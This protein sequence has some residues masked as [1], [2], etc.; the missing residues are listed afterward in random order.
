MLNADSE[1][2][3]MVTSDMGPNARMRLFSS[4]TSPFCRKVLVCALARAISV[5]EVFVD[6]RASDYRANNPLGQIPTMAF[7]NGTCLYDSDVIVQFLDTCH[8]GPSLIPPERFATL[9][10]VHL[11]NGLM[12]AVLSR[13]MELRRPDGERSPSFIAHLEQRVA[14][15]L[16]ALEQDAKMLRTD[17]LDAP[18]VTVMCALEYVDFR[19]PH[20]W[21]NRH[22][23]LATWHL[24][25]ANRRLFALTR[26]SRA[27]PLNAPITS[28]MALASQI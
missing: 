13:I 3:L 24:T 19:Y 15:V 25:L 12:E 5:E 4:P 6:M 27:E 21:R 8:D 22:D 1:R 28:P 10:R 2:F 18:S 11:G 26:P 9:T 17:S 23:A 20:D 14:S 7:D 16:A